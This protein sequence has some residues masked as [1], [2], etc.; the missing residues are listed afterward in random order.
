MD[1]VG[2]VKVGEERIRVLEYAGDL[3]MLAE[4]EKEMRW[5]LKRLKGYS[6]R[7][8][9]EVNVGKTKMVRFRRGWG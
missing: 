1:E 2:G 3:V 7:R 6:N 9:L 4:D 8:G 5:L